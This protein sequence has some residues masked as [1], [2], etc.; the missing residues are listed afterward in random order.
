MNAK[1]QYVRSYGCQMNEYDASRIADLLQDRYQLTRV[2]APEGAD[3][4]VLVTC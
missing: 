3:I 4:V 2:D 1:T